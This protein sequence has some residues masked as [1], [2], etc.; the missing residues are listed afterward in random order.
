MITTFVC[1]NMS[2]ISLQTCLQ[3]YDN[4]HFPIS[5]HVCKSLQCI[6]MDEVQ[7]PSNFSLNIRSH[8]DKHKMQENKAWHK[9]K[10][11]ERGLQVTVAA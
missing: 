3:N 1:H 10:V 9:G 2:E 5:F 7:E 6:L 8:P 4:N 11:G